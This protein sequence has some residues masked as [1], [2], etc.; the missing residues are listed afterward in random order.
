M[1][2]TDKARSD[3]PANKAFTRSE[4][5]LLRLLFSNHRAAYLAAC[6]LSRFVAPTLLHNV[7]VA[8]PRKRIDERT[9]FIE[10]MRRRKL[11]GYQP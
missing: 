8:D 1:K 5:R 3:A 9:G 11:P 4:K 2:P 7:G 6:R 10:L